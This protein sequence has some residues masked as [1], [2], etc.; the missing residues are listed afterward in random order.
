MV[1]RWLVIGT[2]L[3]INLISGSIMWRLVGLGIMGIAIWI[4]SFHR[5]R[6][7]RFEQIKRR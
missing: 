3:I 6:K 2:G 4:G 1:F 7:V 5:K